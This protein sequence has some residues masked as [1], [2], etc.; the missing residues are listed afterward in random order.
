MGQQ[1][2]ERCGE[3]LNADDRAELQRLRRKVRP[4]E[5][6]RNAK[7]ASAGSA[8]HR[9]TSKIFSVSDKRFNVFLGR[10]FSSFAIRSSC[11]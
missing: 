10:S 2:Q 6:E 11:R 3:C 5:L 8:G 1:V 9:N 4:C 7:K